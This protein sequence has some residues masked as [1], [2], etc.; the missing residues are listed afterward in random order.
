M[1]AVDIRADFMSI[2]GNKLTVSKVEVDQP[3]FKFIIDNRGI[4]L[5]HLSHARRKDRRRQAKREKARNQKDAM[6]VEV[7]TLVVREW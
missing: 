3:Y 7:K 4:F 2:L 1:R 5:S 6:P